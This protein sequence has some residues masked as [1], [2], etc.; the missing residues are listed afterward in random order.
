MRSISNL[1]DVSRTHDPPKISF[2]N[3]QSPLFSQENS[4]PRTSVRLVVNPSALCNQEECQVCW[5]AFLHSHL[6]LFHPRS[7]VVH[8]AGG[9]LPWVSPRTLHLNRDELIWMWGSQGRNPL[10]T[11]SID[12]ADQSRGL[13][14]R[15]L[16]LYCP[17]VSFPPTPQLS[18]IIILFEDGS[19]K[20]KICSQ[21]CSEVCR[22]ASREARMFRDD[23]QRKVMSYMR[24]MSMFTDRVTASAV[25]KCDI[26]REQ[27]A[28]ECTVSKTRIPSVLNTKAVIK[29]FSTSLEVVGDREG[30][31]MI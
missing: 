12:R 27:S 18:W 19:S 2:S 22:V 7:M 15:R 23:G 31:T 6:P 30:E 11:C 14:E 24:W 4:W 9:T 29:V 3:Q 8:L 26:T 16:S 21:W 5:L 28:H 20:F 1:Q 10:I 13:R 25:D 17:L